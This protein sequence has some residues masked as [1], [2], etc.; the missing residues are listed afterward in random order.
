[1]KEEEYYNV[2]DSNEPVY[3]NKRAISLGCN[4]TYNRLT[5]GD[6]SQTIVSWRI[7]PIA[8]RT[9][10]EYESITIESSLSSFYQWINNDID[11]SNPFVNIPL[12]ST[13]TVSVYGDYLRF[14]EIFEC[15]PTLNNWNWNT[16]FNR[17]IPN[18]NEECAV[19]W[20]GSH[21]CHTPLH[22]DTYGKNVIIQIKGTKRWKLWKQNPQQDMLPL[23]LP[24]EES[25]IYSSY[26][27]NNNYN[28]PPDYEFVLQQGD[29]LFVP[30]HY[31]HY[32][33][34]ESDIAVSINVWL[35]EDD[36]SHDQ[37]SEALSLFIFGAMKQA[38]DDADSKFCTNDVNNGWIS[39]S[40]IG[41]TL[42][43]ERNSDN[44]D[45]NN[46][47]N[48]IKVGV[49]HES[50]YSILIEALKSVIGR[51]LNDDEEDEMMKK[52]VNRLVNPTTIKACLKD[53]GINM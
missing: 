40:E 53:I 30:K 22:Y 29:V 35:S 15:I 23:R 1:M 24:F 38:V 45:D 4:D 9:V 41:G 52:I 26:D 20:I 13:N 18:F 51:D 43:Y 6:L 10:R 2:I 32:V 19:L 33:E 21:K 31:W 42:A 36:D 50:N 3:L 27:P 49:S 11:E 47:D 7:S 48:N 44:N 12:Y 28:I 37:L 16:L 5:Q 46:D 39:P 8:L 34:T 25:S 17:D 14:K